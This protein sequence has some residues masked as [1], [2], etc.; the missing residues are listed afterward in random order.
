VRARDLAVS[1]A[2]GRLR[3]SLDAMATSYVMGLAREPETPEGE[4]LRAKLHGA[5]RAAC[6]ELPARQREILRLVYEEDVPLK[7]AAGAVGVSYPTALRDHH[8][9]QRSLHA[10][11]SQRG[12]PS[13]VPGVPRKRPAL[14]LVKNPPDEG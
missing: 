13:A 4:L 7:A 3:E 1:D 9:A 6:A 11:F 10:V 12:K 8:E 5:I 2:V 14:R